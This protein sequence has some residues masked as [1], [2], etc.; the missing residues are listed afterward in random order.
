M[1]RERAVQG[2]RV[3]PPELS[4]P[5]RIP[6][7]LAAARRHVPAGL[8][9]PAAW[10]RLQAVRDPLPP[11]GREAALECRLEPGP[12]PVDLELCLR[13]PSRPRLAAAL[14]DGALLREDA[15]GWRR[16]SDLLRAWCDPVSRLHHVLHAVWVEI[17]VPE[18]GARP[19]PFG[20]VTLD[21]ASLYGA[22]VADREVLAS[23]LRESLDCLSGGLD[24]SVASSLDRCLSR[25]PDF[26]QVLHAAVRPTAAGDLVRLVVA[27]PWR[28]A[29]GALAS[30]GW[31]GSPEDLSRELSAL[32]PRTLVHS[33]NLDLG[34]EV[35]PRIGIEF[36]H[37]TAPRED[38]RWIHLLDVLEE[39]GACC[40]RKRRALE[41]WGAR[42]EAGAPG[43]VR[44]ERDLLIKVVTGGEAGMRAKAYLPFSPVLGLG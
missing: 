10:Q 29:P 3:R 22:G 20:V 38:P 41:E 13:A 40:P 18:D 6:E 25:L 27:M 21:A 39:R 37:A 2:G 31:P 4:L 9:D 15:P 11:V 12:G 5:C 17:D 7:M 8:V 35:G 28:H 42:R 44:I 30:L 34:V 14:A 33:F 1:Q 24:P 23:I 16:L 43:L 19:R 36:H 26:A 32:C